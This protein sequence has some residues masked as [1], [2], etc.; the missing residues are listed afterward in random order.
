M[1]ELMVLI[2]NEFEFEETRVSK[3]KR[4]PW[5]LKRDSLEAYQ[6]LKVI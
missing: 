4:L 5:M 2:L 3:V 6:R 1:P